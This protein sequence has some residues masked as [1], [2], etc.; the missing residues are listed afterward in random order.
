MNDTT[1]IFQQRLDK[2]KSTLNPNDSMFEFQDRLNKLRDPV[3]HNHVPHISNL[4]RKVNYGNLTGH[5]NTN[6][7][8]IG[9]EWK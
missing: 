2:L 4:E 3:V 5:Y 7:I 9:T 8:N 6:I 1:K